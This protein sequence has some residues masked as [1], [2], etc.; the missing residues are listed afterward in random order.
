[1]VPAGIVGGKLCN[2]LFLRFKK[3]KVHRQGVGEG[4]N[5]YKM[6]HYVEVPPDAEAAQLV[7]IIEIENFKQVCFRG[8]RNS[9]GFSSVLPDPVLTSLNSFGA[10]SSDHRPY[11]HYFIILGLRRAIV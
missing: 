5:P 1:M 9:V 2:R 7:G 11:E 10:E 8:R 6:S 3:V 4:I